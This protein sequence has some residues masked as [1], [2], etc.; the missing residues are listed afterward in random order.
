MPWKSRQVE[1]WRPTTCDSSEEIIRRA[2]AQSVSDPWSSCCCFLLRQL[3]LVQKSLE[4]ARGAARERRAK[5]I[6]TCLS[7]GGHLFLNHFLELF[8]SLKIMIVD[9]KR[10]Q[11]GVK[12]KSCGA[13]F[14]E[15]MQK[16][17]SV[18]RLHRRVR[19]A[20]EPIPWS[21]QVD[22][23]IKEK[24]IFQNLLS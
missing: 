9:K 17:K 10:F 5:V 23:K 21:A 14:L 8:F 1:P 20:C 22:P 24:H 3:F 15:K 4:H 11:N 12:M 7:Q 16:R 6:G 2:L 13:Y 19:I 18:F